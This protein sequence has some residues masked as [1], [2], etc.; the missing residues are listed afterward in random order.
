[1]LAETHPY[2]DHVIRVGEKLDVRAAN[3]CAR[4]VLRTRQMDR[5]FFKALF[6][7]PLPAR[8]GDVTRIGGCDIACIGPDEW[9]ILAKKE[10]T[11]TI[12]AR[13]FELNRSAPHSLVDVSHRE[14]G[15]EVKG[16]AATLL[17]ASGSPLNLAIQPAPFVTRTIFD[18]VQVILFKWSENHYRIEVWPSFADHV[19]HLLEAA[20]REIALDI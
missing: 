8:I 19:W 17:L 12:N 11:Q 9:F 3:D 10:H 15:F 20:S 1:M 13:S 2:A 18:R 16:A 5:T 14:I 4:F 6:G 7:C